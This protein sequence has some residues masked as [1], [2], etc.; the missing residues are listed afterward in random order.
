MRRWDLAWNYNSL[1]SV[2]LLFDAVKNF[3]ETKIFLCPR[4]AIVT[5]YEI[6][7]SL[8]LRVALVGLL[9]SASLTYANFDSA[10]DDRLGVCAVRTYYGAAGKPAF[11]DR[12]SAAA[13][14]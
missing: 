11:M 2:N 7:A 10:Q 12:L 5:R 9:R 4:Q 13:R 1:P 8:T 14:F 3:C 6:P